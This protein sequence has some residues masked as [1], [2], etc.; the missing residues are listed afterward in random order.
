MRNDRAEKLAKK[1]LGIEYMR[2]TGL[3]DSLEDLLD[4]TCKLIERAGGKLVS[5]QAVALL[6]TMWKQNHPG[7]KPY[8]ED[9]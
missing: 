6:I 2:G 9:G 7:K 5:R 4:D 1:M 8:Y 3:Q